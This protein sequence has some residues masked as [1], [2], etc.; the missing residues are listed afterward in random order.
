MLCLTDVPDV[1]PAKLMDTDEKV[2]CLLKLTANLT[3]VLKWALRYLRDE[4]EEFIF[5]LKK[6][7]LGK[8][9]IVKC[10]SYDYTAV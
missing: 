9:L 7:F 2:R 10:Q 1:D 8:L 6:K 5:P 4:Q 3:S